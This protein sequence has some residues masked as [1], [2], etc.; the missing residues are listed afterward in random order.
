MTDVLPHR[1]DRSLVIHA[2]RETVFGFFTDPAQWASWWG[3]GSTIDARP[4]GDM[5]IRYPNGVEVAGTVLEVRSPERIVFTY[6]YVSGT[7]IPTGDSRVTIRLDAH[8]Q[9][10]LLHLAHEFKDAAAR[11]AHVAGWRFQL[12]VFANLVA[13]TTIGDAT[14]M[15]DR[16]FAAWA[17][18]D[19]EARERAF[20]SLAAPE[21]RFADR[22]S[23]L[24]GLDDLNGHVRAMQQFM[25]GGR[26]E[27]R[28]DVRRSQWTLLADWA[29]LA[30]GG[31]VRATGTTVFTLNADG[32]I[33]SVVGV[34]DEQPRA[35]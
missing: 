9:G 5:W 19:R 2:R 21:V 32:R 20:E 18:T 22:Y 12:S 27:R 30:S 29:A 10:T 24:D 31:E 16:W 3:T 17:M 33:D 4:G 14:G 1:L 11:D 15:I 34:W 13:T 6:G 23:R 7:P 28:G 26:L 35:S 25:P 8:P